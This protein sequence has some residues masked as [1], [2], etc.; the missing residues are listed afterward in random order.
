MEQR[1]NTSG[2]AGLMDRVKESAASQLGAQKDRATDGLGSVAQAVRHSGQQLR[3]QQHET[4]AQYIEQ[5]ADQ[6]DNTSNRRPTSSNGLADGSKTVT[7]AIWRVRRRISLGAVRHC[8]SDP[9]SRS[10]CS[11]RDF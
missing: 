3:D 6:L 8:S 10:A 2:G 4:I 9:L 11:A 1:N 7:S 5:A